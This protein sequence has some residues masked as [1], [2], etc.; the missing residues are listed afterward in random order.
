MNKPH[1]KTNV[2]PTYPL[3]YL[4]QG[5]DES[6]FCFSSKEGGN[7]KGYAGHGVMAVDCRFWEDLE[8]YGY[9][10]KVP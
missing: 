9:F 3:P 7:R 10:S 1:H 2:L 6:N 5:K 8:C 4:S